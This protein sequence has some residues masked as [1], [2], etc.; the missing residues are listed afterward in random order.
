MSF[1]VT[2]I[3]LSLHDICNDCGNKEYT[4]SSLV[5]CVLFVFDIVDF[6]KM[7]LRNGNSVS[8]HKLVIFSMLL[9]SLLLR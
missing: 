8:F 2:D 4:F 5:E 9:W 1:P 7:I 6:K 3:H